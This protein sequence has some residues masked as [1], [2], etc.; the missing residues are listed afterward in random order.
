MFADG[1]ESGNL[2]QWD[3][4]LG[5]GSATATSAAAHTG[6]YGL[7][8]S[9]A[10][11]QFQVLAKGLPQ[12]LADS[13]TTFWVRIASRLRFQTVA[14]ARDGS[15]GAHMWDL[16]YDGG[17]QGFYLFP[18]SNSGSTQIFTGN[19]SAP[20][21]TWL[22]VEIQYTATANGGARIYIND[23]TQASWSVTGNYTRTTNLQRIQL[24]NDGANVTDFDDVSVG[25]PPG[26]PSPPGAPTGV[27]GTA[28]NASANLSWTAPASNG[29]SA[30]TSYRITPYIGAAA[31]TPV[32][33]P[34][35][36]TSYTVTGLTNGTTYTFTVAATNAA[37]TGADSAPS[38][39]IT[40]RA[41]ATVPG[42]PTDV[43]GS[44]GDHSVA[45]G[46]TAPSS[47]GGSAITS[48]RIA[49][50]IG[51]TAQPAINTPTNA[52]TYTV[53]GL[54]NG[55]A[56]TFTVAATNSVGTGAASAASAAVTPR[57]RA[58]SNVRLRGRLRVRRPHEL[59]R[60]AGQR[61]VDGRRGA[62]HA[63]TYGLRTTNTAGQYTF[64]VKSLGSPVADSSVEL[65]GAAQ[66][67]QR[68]ADARRGARRL[69]ERPHV[70][71][72][73]QL[74]HAEPDPRG[75]PGDGRRRGHHRRRQRAA[76]RAGSRSRCSTPR[77]ARAARGS[78]QRRHAAGLDDSGNYTRAAN[79]Q[80]SPALERR[81]RLHRLRRRP[82][83]HAAAA[84]RDAAGRSDRRERPRA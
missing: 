16:Y 72:L 58:T 37:G 33:T 11:G 40:P 69:L 22:K 34:T 59:E 61:D 75:L 31:Q 43:F 79:L 36:A 15:S 64:L 57:R 52:T 47:D 29:G 62:A 70:G 83:R 66:L 5:N 71:S 63:G 28:G 18:Y 8:L 1:F 17:A 80:I 42:A 74:E 3:G 13:S 55:T 51:T 76:G 41:A 54:T 73:L 48:Y 14:E 38:P 32:V 67:R 6:S 4:L 50:Y 25:T 21:G 10:S 20:S 60:V 24:W 19:G 82:D 45:L 78:T 39:P 49:P 77:P 68:P 65:L 81:R 12:P 30:I 9:N 56:Y 84:G 53:T 26:A 46:W 44:P 2:S 23:Q 35:A 7:R 27:T